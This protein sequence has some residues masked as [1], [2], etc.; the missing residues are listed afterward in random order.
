MGNAGA[1]L[2]TTFCL[3]S[4]AA[5]SHGV[6][7][8]RERR[9]FLLAAALH[10]GEAIQDVTHRLDREAREMIRAAVGDI[11]ERQRIEDLPGLA[12]VERPDRRS[13]RFA[14]YLAIEL[15]CLAETHNGDAL[16][17]DA[18]YTTENDAAARCAFHVARFVQV[19]EEAA[20]GGVDVA[21]SD[22]QLAA[23]VDADDDAV[24][25]SSRGVARSREIFHKSFI[26]LL[27][28]R[29]VTDKTIG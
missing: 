4:V 22:A 2:G 20:A 5:R 18:R 25:G 12:A 14:K 23:L 6:T 11:L 13:N 19:L 10:L 8:R 3:G 17:L 24:S 21:G 28:F 29:A 1:V 27:F 9:G 26:A 7:I 16:G 15:R